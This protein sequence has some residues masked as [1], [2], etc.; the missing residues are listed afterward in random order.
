MDVSPDRFDP[1][2][3]VLSQ[4]IIIERHPKPVVSPRDEQLYLRLVN[5]AFAM[6][7]KTLANNLKA[8]F[9]LDNDGAK[10]VLAAAGVDEKVRGEALSLQALC[11]VADAI[12]EQARS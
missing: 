4:F 6:R 12:A 1:P 11:R 2:P 10:A 5:A 8:S 9:G 3:H 7:R